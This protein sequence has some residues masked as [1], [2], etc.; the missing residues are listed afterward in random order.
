MARLNASDIEKKLRK[1][2]FILESYKPGNR[3]LY[4]VSAPARGGTRRPVSVFMTSSELKCWMAGF[5]VGR[6]KIPLI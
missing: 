3:R 1:Y 5:E 6:G 4:R 2:G